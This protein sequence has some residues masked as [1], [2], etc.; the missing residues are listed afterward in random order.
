MDGPLRVGM[1]GTSWFAETVH[2]TCLESH[3]RAVLTAV[4]GRDRGN[5]EALAARHGDP[6]VFTDFAEMMTSGLLDAVVIV[7][8]DDL[9]HEMTLQALDAGLHVLCE[10]PLARSA[11]DAHQMWRA[12]E[13]AGRVHM[14]MFTWRWLGV[15]SYARRLIAEGYLGRCRHAHFSMQ[16]DYGDAADYGW[17]IDPDHGSGILGDLGSHLIDLARCCVGE[18]GA[19]SGKLT[20]ALTRFGPDGKPTDS[21][22]DSAMMLVE[23]A[24]GADGTLEV[25]G[26]RLVGAAGPTIE[27]R[28]YGDDGT[29]RL[30]F[31]LEAGRL[32]GRRRGEESWSDL[33][34]PEELS[35]LA[36]D[37]PPI[38]DLAMLAPF[39]NLPVADRLF[40]DAVV[41]GRPA[42][43][44]F[45]DG[46][47]AQ[48]V[49]DA[50]V[51]SDLQRGWVAVSAV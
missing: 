10:K 28:L 15:P 19:V 27:I 3:P 9:H 50:V 18:I 17:R 30:D 2:L 33:T 13:A 24:D 40:V 26:H 34:V 14:T 51:A 46:W 42:E 1:V 48:Q 20:T 16:A 23:F 29:L 35:G 39:T 37:N 45:E 5:A 4:C 41:D 21:L 22:N 7:T 8:P 12:A 44:T 36:G 47:R 31:G 6:A 25:S 49:V 11:S 38:L 32:S 43:A